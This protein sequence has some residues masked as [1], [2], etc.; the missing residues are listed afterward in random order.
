M[1]KIRVSTQYGNSRKYIRG[2]W[3]IIAA[4]EYTRKL[5]KIPRFAPEKGPIDAPPRA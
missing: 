1:R 4:F 2:L 3:K 5:I